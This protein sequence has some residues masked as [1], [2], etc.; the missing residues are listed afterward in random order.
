MYFKHCLTLRVVAVDPDLPY[1]TCL[2][3]AWYIRVPAGSCLACALPARRS[4]LRRT[5]LLGRSGGAALRAA[6]GGGQRFALPSKPSPETSKPSP[7]T[8]K[9][10]PETSEPSLETSKPNHRLPK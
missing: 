10:S 9:P 5:A 6:F 2:S 7:Q 3:R 1:L 8:S 4:R